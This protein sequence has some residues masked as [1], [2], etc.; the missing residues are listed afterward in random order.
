TGSIRWHSPMIDDISGAKSW[1]KVNL[2]LIKM[3]RAEVIGKLPIMQHFMFGSLISF[4][5]GSMPA[6]VAH[7]VDEGEH[8]CGDHSHVFALGQEFPDCCGIKVP[9][10]IAAALASKDASAGPRSA[11]VRPIPFD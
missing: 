9:S 5:G 6:D 4:T 10:A 11:H 8:D 2:G 1:E 7:G 3:F